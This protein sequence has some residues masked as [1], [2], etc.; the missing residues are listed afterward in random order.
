MWS[1]VHRPQQP[2]SV[3]KARAGKTKHPGSQGG[4]EL[5]GGIRGGQVRAPSPEQGRGC[6]MGDFNDCM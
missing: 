3:G 5:G 4:P 2:D 1:P 6:Q